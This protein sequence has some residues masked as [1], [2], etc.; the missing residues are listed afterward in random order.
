MP[1]STIAQYTLLKTLGSGASAKVKLC[2]DGSGNEFAI[3][4]FD[5]QNANFNQKAFE[6]LAKEIDIYKAMDH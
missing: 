1:N 6:Y 2:Q 4:I 3:K 5:R